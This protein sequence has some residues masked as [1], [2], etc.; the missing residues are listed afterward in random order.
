MESNLLERQ[1]LLRATKANIRSNLAYE[2]R[3]DRDIEMRIE[4]YRGHIRA[5]FAQAARGERP[6][7][8]LAEGDSW[9]RYVV[10]K[11]A[12]FYVDARPRNEVLNLA[13]P[14]DEV[15]DM[16]T[17]K[18]I[19]RLKRELKRGPSRNRKYDAFL[20]SG[21]GN[22]LL[23]QGRFRIWLKDYRN[24]MS[25]K[26][27]INKSALNVIIRYLEDRYEEIIG[28]RNDL[29]PK[30]KMYLHSYD[31]A[32]PNGKGVCGTGPWLQPGLIERSVPAA[33]RADVVAEFLKVFARMLKRIQRN[34][35]GVT[36]VDTQGT[37]RP[38]EWANE[39]HPKNSGFKKIGTKIAIQVE[40]DL[41]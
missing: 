5:V 21:G 32:Q 39:I 17:P 16:M 13:S 18:Q 8:I 34:N 31:F 19:K 23:G 28:F 22:D 12:L 11:S 41:P 37:L 10:G 9:F 1:S 38:D 30:T 40:S 26:D 27:V 35:Q 33:I 7:C 20:F 15:R 36:V 3:V 14:G 24:G 25:A 2:R 29:S 6:R 4:T